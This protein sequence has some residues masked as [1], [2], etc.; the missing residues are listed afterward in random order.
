MGD[1]RRAADALLGAG[2]EARRRA[3][4][5][6]SATSA[7][8]SAPGG[9][10]VARRRR[11]EAARQLRA[12]G[13]AS[14]AA[15]RRPPSRAWRAKRIRRRSRRRRRWCRSG[16]PSS[17][18]FS[19]ARPSR[20]ST[21]GRATTA[22]RGVGRSVKE[23]QDVGRAR[24]KLAAAQEELKALE[25]ELNEEI[26]ALAAVD[27]GAVAIETIEVKP[28]RGGVDVRLVALAWKAV[29]RRGLSPLRRRNAGTDAR[30]PRRPAR[31]DRRLPA[32]PVVLV[33]RARERAA[34]SPG[35]T[36][37]LFRLIGEHSRQAVVLER[38][39]RQ[40]PPLQGA[41][42]ADAGHA[43]RDPLLLPALSQRPRP[44]DDLLRLPAREGLHPAAH[45]P[46]SSRELRQN[47][48]DRELLELRRA[49]RRDARGGLRATAARRSR[50]STCTRPRCSSRSCR[51]PTP[52]SGSRSTRRLPL[53]L[54]R[55][56]REAEAAFPSDRGDRLV[57]D[58]PGG[59]RHPGG[60]R[61]AQT[62]RVAG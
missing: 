57:G 39:P 12:E 48:A 24:E 13:R 56:R 62:E 1:A 20:A 10:R 55:A 30:W 35:G 19:A 22:V 46:S 17:A 49:G 28:K 2:G 45:A 29:V 25:N 9:A 4:A 42:A 8:G 31:H 44:A 34:Q 33:R 40:V 21:L 32:L 47:V 38:R 5:R 61:L 58:R 54:L 53:D 59:R 3:P 15:R 41:A 11:R 37:A 14:D 50:C 16:P 18:R 23:T 51:K 7:C 36:L 26:A 27:S 43:A 52:G 60:G 6:A